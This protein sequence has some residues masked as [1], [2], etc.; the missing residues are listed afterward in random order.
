MIKRA[1]INVS[2][3]EVEAVLLRHPMVQEVAVVGVP[4]AT[5]GERIFAFVVPS[6][7][8]PFDVDVLMRHCAAQASKYKLPDHI[9]SCSRLPLTV[10]GKLQRRELKKL[11]IDRA[12][13]LAAG[14]T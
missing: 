9:E 11:A 6:A 5:R 12:R 3:A 1:G 4:D 10:T 8:E 2:P 7:S 14:A 13:S